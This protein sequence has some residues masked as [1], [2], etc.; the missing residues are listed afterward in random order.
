MRGELWMQVQRPVPNNMAGVYPMGVAER[1]TG[2]SRRQ[3]RYYESA[4][5]LQ[6][7]RTGGGHRLYSDR[8]VQTLLRIKVLRANGFH[9]MRAVSRA[10]R[11]DAMRP[12]VE[13]RTLHTADTDSAS[14][15]RRP[16]VLPLWQRPGTQ[17]PSV[18]PLQRFQ[19]RK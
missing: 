13:S 9:T 16:Q 7:Q 8:D 6:P 4:G 10:I 12:A 19:R 14:Y 5:L 1:V 3:I 18:S 2:L 11:A 17:D 15:F